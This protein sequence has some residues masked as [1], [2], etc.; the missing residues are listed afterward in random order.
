MRVAA[1]NP[2]TVV[3]MQN[4]MISTNFF[5]GRVYHIARSFIVLIFS[6]GCPILSHEMKETTYRK[7][8]DTVRSKGGYKAVVIWFNRIVTTAVYLLYPLLLL[9]LLWA[10][11]RGSAP[12]GDPAD[13]SGISGLMGNGSTADTAGIPLGRG[14]IPALLIPGVSFIILSVI[15]DRINSPRPYEVFDIPPVIDKKTT[16]HSF[17]SRHI[18]SIFVIATTFFYFFPAFG[19]LLAIVGALLAANRVIGG[20]HFLRDVIA[21]ALSGI[22]AGVIGYY[23]ILPLII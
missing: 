7:I 17:P 10:G 20:V 3:N 11:V 12:A 18:F 19:I 5:M 16:G 1:T 15:R 22:A 13:L 14:F 9:Y 21:G 2:M 6:F 23:L 8:S 4:I